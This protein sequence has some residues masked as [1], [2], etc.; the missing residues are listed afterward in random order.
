VLEFA[1]H[2]A[3]WIGRRVVIEEALGESAAES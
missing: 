2:G 1:F 3:R